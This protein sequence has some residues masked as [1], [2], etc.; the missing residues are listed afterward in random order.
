MRIEKLRTQAKLRDKDRDSNRD[1]DK[2]RASI[3]DDRCLL[4]PK[5]LPGD[6]HPPT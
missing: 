6:T 1:R 5:F 4:K 3:G 2:D